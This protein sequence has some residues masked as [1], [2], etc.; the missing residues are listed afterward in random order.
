MNT[1]ATRRIIILKIMTLHNTASQLV[2]QDVW[3]FDR[4]LKTPRHFTA[5]GGLIWCNKSSLPSPLNIS[6]R[7]GQREL[8]HM[9]KEVIHMCIFWYRAFLRFYDY[10]IGF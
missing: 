5:K 6:T 4:I 7:S 2:I 1:F 9:C 10:P 3:Y 8:I